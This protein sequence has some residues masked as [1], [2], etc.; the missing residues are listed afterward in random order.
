V[1]RHALPHEARGALG[2]LLEYSAA[3]FHQ[4]RLS[5][6]VARRHGFDVI[7]ACNPPDLIF[8]IGL[9]YKPWGKRFL[10]DHHDLSPELYVAKFKVEALL[11]RL[12]VRLLLWCERLT[13]RIST[14]SIATNE[15]Y[16]QIAID[17]GRMNPADVHVVRSGPNLNKVR[18]MPAD[19]R[20]KNGRAY[21]IGYVG[22]IGQQEGLDLLLASVE[23]IVRDRNRRDIQ[24]AVVG[25]GPE[26]PV[27]RKLATQRG[28][29]EFVTFT[30]RA[31]DVTLLTILSTA[32]V[33]VNPDRFNAMNDK[34]TM[35]KILE[36]MAL[37]KPIVQYDLVEGRFSAQDASL[38]AW[39]NNPIN[40]ADKILQLLSDPAARASMG[41]F[42]RERVEKELSWEHEAPKLLAAYEALFSRSKRFAYSEV[43]GLADTRNKG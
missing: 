20:W 1:Y 35:N 18:R 2:Y 21:L 33:C 28:L 37:G 26:L 24:F 19:E 4:L 34:S 23:H 31:D 13:F 43:R 10:F 27:I 29:D 8:L 5:I 15:S 17:R 7:H 42:G 9:F 41:R 14:I 40:F 6:R 30:G 25:D 36:Y 22:V 16:R 3:L 12:V 38:Y 32:D 39:R 11:H